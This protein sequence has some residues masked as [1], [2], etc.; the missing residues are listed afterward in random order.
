M[1]TRELYSLIALGE[2]TRNVELK[3]SI[4]WDDS[5]VKARIAKTVLGMSN[6]R[7]GGFL[8]LGVEQEGDDFNPVGI[9]DEH[10]STF[11][12]DLVSSEVAKFADP[13]AVFRMETVEDLES[14]TRKILKV[15]KKN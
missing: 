11:N 14:K 3:R 9:T 2:Q 5:D 10:L 15:N 6:I 13:Y 1:N 4:S 7:N 8:I 12:Y